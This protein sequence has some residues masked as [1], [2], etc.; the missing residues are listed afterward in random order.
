MYKW[1]CH[2]DKRIGNKSKVCLSSFF[3]VTEMLLYDIV[4]CNITYIVVNIPGYMVGRRRHLFCMVPSVNATSAPYY[5]ISYV[6]YCTSALYSTIPCVFSCKSLKFS[7]VTSSYNSTTVNSWFLLHDNKTMVLILQVLGATIDTQ[8]EE[9]GDV[10]SAR[11]EPA[12][13]PPCPTIR[14]LSCSNK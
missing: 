1:H 10:G 2:Y 9:M 8:W 13:L 12:L 14:V 3:F 5:F 4:L 7:A 11:Y 6:H